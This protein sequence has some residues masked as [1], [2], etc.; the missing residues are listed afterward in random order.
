ML[1]PPKQSYCNSRFDQYV[2]VSDSLAQYLVE[3]NVNEAT[4]VSDP[5]SFPA[6]RH[7]STFTPTRGCMDGDPSLAHRS[8]G[9]DWGR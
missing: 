4:M 5:T 8:S 7:L 2:C 6:A 3:T 9:A 1:G